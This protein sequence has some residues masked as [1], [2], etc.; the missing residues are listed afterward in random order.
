MVYMA[1]SVIDDKIILMA[2]LAVPSQLYES[3]QQHDQGLQLPFPG[4]AAPVLH[5]ATSAFKHTGKQLAS[6]QQSAASRCEHVRAWAR[7]HMMQH[8][9]SM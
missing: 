5:L 8:C 2:A 1:A 3:W 4:C 6:E 9:W 7:Q